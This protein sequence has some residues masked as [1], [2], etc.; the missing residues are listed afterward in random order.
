MVVKF[1]WETQVAEA[2]LEVNDSTFTMILTVK[3]IEEGTVEKLRDI[4]KELK[5]LGI[6]PNKEMHLDDGSIQFEVRCPYNWNARKSD[7]R[8]IV[9]EEIIDGLLGGKSTKEPQR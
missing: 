5:D 8:K 4:M 9:R 1:Y 3:N 7:F 6:Y 2:C